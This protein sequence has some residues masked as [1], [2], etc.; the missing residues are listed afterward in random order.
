MKNGFRG[1]YV[2]FLAII[3]MVIISCSELYIRSGQRYS[4]MKSVP[5]NTYFD[6]L[7][8]LLGGIK[9]YIVSPTEAFVVPIKW[10]LLQVVLLYGTLYYPYRDLHSVGVSVLP[11]SGSRTQ[12]WISK[13]IWM[14]VCQ[15]CSYLVIFITVG[16][17]CL[18]PGSVFSWQVT[19]S[20]VNDFFK[21]KMES[22]TI[23][24]QFSVMML[25]LPMLVTIS[26][27][28]LQ[29][30]LMLFIKPIFSFGIS[31]II[32][33]SSAYLFSLFLIGNYA[34]PVRSVYIV[35]RGYTIE[36]GICACMAL[37]VLA[38]AGGIRKFKKYDV[39]SQE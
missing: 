14:T 23:S 9:E 37:A 8:Y 27:N 13:C 36:E 4:A 2:H 29:M 5:V 38:F 3:V 21:I 26:L 25:F 28:M 15:I 1:K 22:E 11:R 10:L 31:T 39:L 30:L 6:Y 35:K 7:C 19:P 34:M 32:M 16:V 12:W 24:K 17:F 33:T 18:V 20:L